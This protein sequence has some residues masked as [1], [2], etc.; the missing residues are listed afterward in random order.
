M[1]AIHV[2]EKEKVGK[3]NE[4]KATAKH[5]CV[6]RVDNTW[7]AIVTD[8]STYVYNTTWRR[9]EKSGFSVFKRLVSLLFTPY[10]K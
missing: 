10:Q 6:E 7:H 3:R 1:R 5:N 8:F 9:Y 4:K 2:A